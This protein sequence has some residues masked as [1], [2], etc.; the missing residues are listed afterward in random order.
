MQRSAS[1]HYDEDR[2]LFLDGTGLDEQNLPERLGKQGARNVAVRRL[3]HPP[4]AILLLESELKGGERLC[5]FYV[6]IGTRARTV[7]YLG[8]T[9]WSPSDD[10]VWSRLRDAVAAGR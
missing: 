6:Q 5:V 4:V 3:D 10:V 1:L 8:H 7:A 2:D 9:P